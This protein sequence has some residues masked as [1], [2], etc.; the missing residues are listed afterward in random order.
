MPAAISYRTS[1]VNSASQTSYTFT[2]QDIGT[3][4]SDRRVVV[5]VTFYVN[6]GSQSV[7]SVTIGGVS[8]SALYDPGAVAATAEGVAFWSAIVPTGT[9]GDIV[10]NFSSAPL[11]IGIGVW[12]V[13][14]ASSALFDSKRATGTGNPLSVSIGVPANGAVIAVAGMVNN[15]TAG[16]Y[17][18]VGLTENYD[19]VI[20]GAGTHSGSSGTF[21][22]ANAALTVSSTYSQTPNISG[23]LA[24][25]AFA[26][27]DVTMSASAGS[28]ALTGAPLTMMRAIHLIAAA[29]N[30]LLT[31]KPVTRGFALLCAAGSY[32]LTGVP[33]IV[34]DLVA[35]AGKFA[36]RQA[37]YVLQKIRTTPPSLDQ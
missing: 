35:P 5:G 11:R 26:P 1:A 25:I 31:G 20:G 12:A 16:T 9:T 36:I 21:S 33:L 3:A 28:Y 27:R 22:S 34:T 7:S 13:T 8:A 10:I 30:Y 18:W 19:A 24:V 15:G 23:S 32:T 29:G 14:A 17:T 2:A 6:S 37:R 4:S